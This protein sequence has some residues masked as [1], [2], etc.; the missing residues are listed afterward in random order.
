MPNSS[1]DDLIGQDLQSRGTSN[2][3]GVSDVSPQHAVTGLDTQALTG[4]PATAGMRSPED[5]QTQALG[6]Q[7]QAAMASSPAVGTWAA[8]AHPAHLAVTQDD[9][10][11]LAKIAQWFRTD[12][13]FPQPIQDILHVG[14]LLQ[15]GISQSANEYIQ[16]LGQ[17]P[18][19]SL[20]PKD[21]APD[22]KQLGAGLSTLFGAASIPFAVA[23]APLTEPAARALAPHLTQSLP[24]LPWEQPHA[25]TTP[26]AQLNEAR[27]LV[28]VAVTAGTLG[29]GLRGLFSG[30]A[31]GATGEGLPP[32]GGTGDGSG[33]EGGGPLNPSI[34][35]AHDAEQVAKVQEEVAASQ[36]HAR[37]P[38]TMQTFLD[39]QTTH[40]VAVDPDTF[41]RL[42]PQAEP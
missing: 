24:L 9:F 29:A 32:E 26:D 41:L 39:Q 27:N 12:S 2:V 21:Y 3:A 17:H 1:L 42:P 11:S 7:Q 40:T 25:L 36:T 15:K 20:N 8:T 31:K 35:A 4:L 10:P 13:N 37:S 28:N 6:A 14:D 19:F 33:P 30:A 18:L 16:T 22:V 5:A 23:T 38:S 34:L